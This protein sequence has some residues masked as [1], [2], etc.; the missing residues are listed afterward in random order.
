LARSEAE[1]TK[2]AIRN[3]RRDANAEFKNL[4]KDKDMT[5]DELRQAEDRIQKVTDTHVSE[6]DQMLK[7]KE[8]SLMEI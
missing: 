5:D 2:V 3:I 6:V 4:N 1:Q 7:V 8:E